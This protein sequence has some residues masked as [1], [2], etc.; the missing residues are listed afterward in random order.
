MKIQ[1]TNQDDFTPTTELVEEKQQETER[2]FVGRIVPH[3]NHTLFEYD[4]KNKEL[5]KA[6]FDKPPVIKF[7]DA[8]KGVVSP[9]KEVTQK[10]HHLYLS[11]LNRKNAIKVLKRTYNI[12]VND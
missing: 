7:T 6:V 4:L 5:R 9:K 1:P 10:E 8:Q 12:T 3:R 11:C 2:E